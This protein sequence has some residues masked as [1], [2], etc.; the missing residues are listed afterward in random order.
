MKFEAKNLSPVAFH[1]L[2]CVEVIA[3]IQCYD[4]IKMAA[5]VLPVARIDE[6]AKPCEPVIHVLRSVLS[7]CHFAHF[8]RR[9]FNLIQIWS[10]A[11]R[12]SEEAKTAVPLM[13]VTMKLYAAFTEL[14]RKAVHG[15]KLV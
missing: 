15:C 13:A 7:P 1:A 10:D 4:W 2:T 5:D 14:S 3:L 11:A 12:R 8:D 6:Y 9:Q